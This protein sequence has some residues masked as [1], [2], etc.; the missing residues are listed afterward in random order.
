[1]GGLKA[2]VLEARTKMCQEICQDVEA[3][4]LKVQASVRLAAENGLVPQFCA[5]LTCLTCA[6][7]DGAGGESTVAVRGEEVGLLLTF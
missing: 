6:L 2:G 1:M 3:P 5:Q 4:P 7:E